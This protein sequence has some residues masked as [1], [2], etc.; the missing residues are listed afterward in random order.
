MITDV[1]DFEGQIEPAIEQ[2]FSDNSI[3]CLT[4]GSVRPAPE[5]IPRQRVEA[6]FIQGARMARMSVPVNDEGATL[7]DRRESAWK[8]RLQVTVIT[9]DNIKAHREFRANVRNLMAKFHKLANGIKLLYHAIQF[10]I[11]DL[12]CSPT[13]KY[14]E[15]FFA[16]TMTYEFSF[17]IL[18]NA[19]PRLINDDPVNVDGVS[20]PVFPFTV[21]DGMIVVL[22]E[23][24]QKAGWRVRDRVTGK[25][26]I[27]TI[28]DGQFMVSTT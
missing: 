13:Y 26:V 24:G 10:P 11:N 2:V 9:E 25:Y 4:P 5:A 19:W 17:S 22:D 14:A 15:G 6:I 18:Q 7:T 12:G 21:D 28:Q 3:F 23:N 16:T 20:S 27:V 1:Y 8:C